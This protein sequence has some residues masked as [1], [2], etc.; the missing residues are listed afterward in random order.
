MSS[1]TTVLGSGRWVRARP[2]PSVPRVLDTG[3]CWY[4]DAASFCHAVRSHSAALY[5]M[6]LTWARGLLHHLP[7]V[8][9][10]AAPVTSTHKDVP[11]GVG[12]V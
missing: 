12:A 10:N 5:D 11:G 1:A 4:L 8:L 7:S 2:T 9:E 6:G 3:A